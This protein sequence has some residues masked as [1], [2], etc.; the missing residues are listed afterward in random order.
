[1]EERVHGDGPAGPREVRMRRFAV[2]L[3]TAAGQEVLDPKCRVRVEDLMDS[4]SRSV[5]FHIRGFIWAEEDHVRR[6]EFKVPATW[7]Q[8][9]KERFFRGWLRRRFPVRYQVHSV[10]VEA[11]YPEFRQAMPRH[12][13]GLAVLMLSHPR[14]DF[15]T[16]GVRRN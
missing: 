6:F 3:E 13:A 10:D 7:W 5:R 4:F 9:F 15:W 2:E 14:T 11:I 1:M 8:H 12:E 16:E